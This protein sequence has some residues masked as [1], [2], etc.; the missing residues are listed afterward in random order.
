VEGGRC[1]RRAA[2]EQAK[3]AKPDRLCVFEIVVPCRVPELLQVLP[4]KPKPQGI[5]KA[6]GARV[7]R[8]GATG[9]EPA[10]SGVT[11]SPDQKR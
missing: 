8:A 5:K 2:L 3:T 1:V 10:T 11:M 7:S 9:L 6:I 4:R